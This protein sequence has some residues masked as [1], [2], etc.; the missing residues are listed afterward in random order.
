[1]KK[2]MGLIVLVCGLVSYPCFSF[3]EIISADI[4]ITPSSYSGSFGGFVGGDGDTSALS[5]KSSP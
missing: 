4:V 3:S 5:Q 1:M 2:L